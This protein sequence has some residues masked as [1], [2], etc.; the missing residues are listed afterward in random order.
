MWKRKLTNEQVKEI[1]ERYKL[2]ESA[3]KLKKVYSMSHYGILW[4]LKKNNIKIR[5]N[6]D[7]PK[8]YKQD[9]SVFD[10]IN[11]ES[12]YWVGILLSDGSISDHGRGDSR[13]ILGLS[14]QEHILKFRLFMKSDVPI[15]YT[16]QNIRKTQARLV[17]RSQ[18]LIDKLS[19]YN[20][21]PRKS[22]TATVPDI[23]KDNRHFWRGMVDGDGYILYG[24]KTK[25][26]PNYKYPLL[27]LTGSYNVTT[28][29]ADYIK[30]YFP[31]SQSYA[32]KHM[33]IYKTTVGG[34]YAV[35]IIKLLYENCCV[36]LDRKQAIANKIINGN[37]GIPTTAISATMP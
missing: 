28:S 9:N 17:L 10:E 16:H 11:E 33:T 26:Y 35:G 24:C 18:Q 20:I 19:E 8:K 29:F 2:G 6:R 27:G 30:N 23:L 5:E 34:K 14:D 21:V 12:A 4:N 37:Y 31:Q 3:E 32:K 15:I 25:K 1:C 36:S 22:L 13:V 7:Y